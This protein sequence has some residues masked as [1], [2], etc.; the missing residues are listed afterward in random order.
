MRWCGGRCGSGKVWQFQS[1]P[2]S[3]QLPR[4]WWSRGCFR[5]EWVSTYF[6]VAVDDLVAMAEVQC[7]CNCEHNLSNLVLVLAAVQVVLAAQFT[8]LAVLHDYVEE[9]RVVVD[10]VNFH[11]VGV[12]Q[13]C[14]MGHYRQHYLALVEVGVKILSTEFLPGSKGRITFFSD[15]VLVD[16]FDGVDPPVVSEDR[17]ADL[18]KGSSTYAL[19][20]LAESLLENIVLVDVG[21]EDKVAH[22]SPY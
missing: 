17:L 5:A 9:A 4:L 21:G 13:L 2:A 11:D 19:F 3:E 20:L 6:D 1:L 16:D 7:V 8:A 14:Q 15:R 18:G 12:L 22:H 10:L